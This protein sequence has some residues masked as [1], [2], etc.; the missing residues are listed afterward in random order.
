MNRRRFLKGLGVCIALPALESL[1]PRPLVSAASGATSEAAAG[2]AASGAAGAAVTATG[3]PL[4]TAVIYFPNGA[5][6]ANW[7]PTGAGETFALNKTMEPLE[8][9]KYKMQILGGLDDVS[10]NPGPDG[11]GDHARANSTFLSG[12]RIKKTAGRDYY[13]GISFD[14]VIAKNVGHVTP[15]SSLEISCDTVRNA[16][17]CDTGYSCIYEHNLAWS[18]P[19]TPMTP[20]VNPAAAF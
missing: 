16:G 14:Q 12:V 15:Y 19:T 18:S 5:I 13:S 3:A 11:G 2:A 7:W 8:S 10:A 4:R 9:L 6:P 20:E 1:L 17:A